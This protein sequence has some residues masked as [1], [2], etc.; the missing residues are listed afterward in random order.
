MRV[1]AGGGSAQTTGTGDAGRAAEEARRA[2]EAAAKAAAEAAKA[3]AEVARAQS[4]GQA[5][6]PRQR[7]QAAAQQAQ[8]AQQ[9]AQT[10]LDTLKKQPGAPR[11]EVAR[12]EQALAQATQSARN[13]AT[14]ARTASTNTG[15]A[16]TFTAASARP[17]A[18]AGPPGVTPG[19]TQA[20]AGKDAD[21]LHRA[22][23]GGVTGLGTDEEAVFRILDKRSPA[24][25]AMIRQAFQEH[26]RLDLNSTIR[27]E[28]SGT[29][30]QRANAILAGKSSN[31]G[32]AAIRQQTEGWIGG[33]KD[34]VIRTLQDAPPAERKA[35][36]RSFQQMYANEFR[37]VK[38]SS[39]EEFME[40]ALS[41]NLNDAQRSQLHHLLATTQAS[42]PG[43]V[44]QLETA[45]A[46]SQVHDALQ[47]FFGAD[48]QKVFDTLDKL[49][50]EQ[51]QVL[52]K[53]TALQAELKSKLSPEDFSR[54]RGLLESNPASSDAAKIRG[55]QQGWFGADKSS[56]LDVLKNTKPE[57]MKALKAAYREQTGK[58][59]ESVVRGFGG[60][61]AEVGLR[62]LHPAAPND[63]Q[64]QAQADAERLHRAMDRWGTDA[65]ALR[66]VLGNKSKAQINLISDAYQKK[67]GKD[68][69]ADLGSELSGRDHFE[70]VQQAFDQGAIDAKAPDA[71]QQ[72]IARLRAQQT[73]EQSAGLGLV[74]KVQTVF[75][76]ESDSARLERMLG[77][78]EKK[79]AQGDRVA[80][81][82]LTGY[83]TNDIKDVQ[84]S[85]DSAA[86]MA[87]TAAVA[88]GTTAAVV[89]SGGAATPL[90]IAGYAA[91]GA[92][93]RTATQMLIKGD[94]LGSEG[95]VQQMAV[96]A[97][98]GA[99]AVVPVPK[100]LGGATVTQGAE[101]AVK[102]TLG[103][104]LR[105]TAVRSGWES[106]IGGAASGALD[107]ALQDG[108]WDNGFAEGMSRVVQSSASNAV[109]GAVVG[110]GTGAGLETAGHA[111]KPR[112]VAVVAN[113]AFEGRTT[114]AVYRDGRVR[115]EKGPNATDVDVQ[116]HMATAKHLQGY[117]GPIGQVRKLRDRLNQALTGKPGY[118]TQGFESQL[119][120]KKLKEMIHTLETQEAH[121]ASSVQRLGEKANLSPVDLESIQREIGDLRKQLDAHSAQVDSL[122]PPRGFVAAQD[123]SKS[124][125][126]AK[127]A[128]MPPPPDG[129]FYRL[130][131]DKFE[132]VR[133]GDLEK[134]KLLFDPETREF[135][136]DDGVRIEPKFAAG[137]T[138]TEAFRQLGADKP[139][140]DFGK[141]IATMERE[142]L[143]NRDTLVQQ[144]RADPGGLNFSTVRHELKEKY[145]QALLDRA[146]DPKRL[147]T[148]SAF[149]EVFAKT[150]DRQQALNA[151]S[152]TE[153]LRLS[154]GLGASDKGSLGERWYVKT[155][156]NG[157][158][159]THV[160]ITQAAAKEA[161][162]SLESGRVLDVLDGKVIR[163]LKNVTTPLGLREK[164]Q[165]QDLVVLAKSKFS[166]GE[167]PINS[168]TEVMLAPKGVKANA[169]WMHDM[170]N[171]ENR[172]PLQFEIFNEKG[173]S[174][175]IT[176]ENR[177]LL[178]D[179]VRLEN[180][181]AG[182]AD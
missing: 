122:A 33:D 134:D 138:P 163:E 44:T 68:L 41:A 116:A 16:S 168:V 35:I 97:V 70:I 160:S 23:K 54:T 155:F 93:T 15:S 7:A 76:G 46:R 125:A 84:T 96:G 137:T 170:L 73:F 11:A 166:V 75:K 98:E 159:R 32:A 4:L 110:A 62:Y 126:A 92:G 117:E 22:M 119:E 108:T 90:A 152:H 154:E 127:A 175:L 50:P 171:P 67:Y 153:M 58:S 66:E 157:G 64:A 112:E 57:N 172:L 124:D 151:A 49:P 61:D 43:K 89:L 162:I 31:N 45:T 113:P 87:A 120:V 121:I 173:V 69:R 5:E 82:R 103:Q 24:D 100:G 77:T 1:N 146:T 102:Q 14:A 36:A 149:Q 39:P 56:I 25:I 38:A 174:K 3:A 118:G 140:S 86:D 27:E 51:R 99:T 83:A 178:A 180:F 65:G 63:T 47:G 115:I 150:K 78:A 164:T 129:Y 18:A 17:Q 53:D 10:A 128:G 148:M 106:G 37:H 107:Q 2:A 8:Q 80:A 144:L 28:L 169:K 130:K 29:D 176:P 12:A 179:P 177:D 143:A 19:Y 52:L 139:D 72:Q 81:S 142:G 9:K 34:A 94:S 21:E 158:F 109:I 20:Q 48:S 161:G 145:A 40:K 26:H 114:Q 135:V 105:G 141:W 132:V 74:N 42:T 30:L 13:A 167:K 88:V 6:G 95:I 71:E 182:K 55:Q 111:L 104:Q 156:D 147:E 165:I 136:R 60:N 123:V 85:K 59:L 181:L 79:L 91:V 131:N 101:A 133:H